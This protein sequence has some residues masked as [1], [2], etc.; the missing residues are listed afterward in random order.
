VQVVWGDRKVRGG[1]PET[2]GAMMVGRQV[3]QKGQLYTNWLWVLLH[4]LGTCVGNHM[5]EDDRDQH[6]GMAPWEGPA[7]GRWEWWWGGGGKSGKR[8]W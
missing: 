6:I 4:L 3:R 2:V 1:L 7:W 8:I 5:G